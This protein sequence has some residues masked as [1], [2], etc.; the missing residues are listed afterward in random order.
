M[1]SCG[2]KKDRRKIK[3]KADAPKVIFIE[4]KEQL[5]EHFGKPCLDQSALIERLEQQGKP[6]IIRVDNDA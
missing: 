4:T 5:I 3:K 1:V 6:G 2:M